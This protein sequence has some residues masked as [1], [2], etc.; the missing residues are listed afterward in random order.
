MSKPVTTA[1][2]PQIRIKIAKLNYQYWSILA[3]KVKAMMTANIGLYP[4]PNPTLVTLTTFITALDTT[5]AQ[6][7]T[8]HNKGGK[9]QILAVRVAVTDVQNTLKQLAQYVLNTVD[10]TLPPQVQAANIND[11]GFTQKDIRS[12][13]PT[14]QFVKFAKQSNTKKF[15]A[16]LRRI[17]WKKPLGLIKGSQLKS[18][19]LY[20]N[21][22]GTYLMTT[23]RCNTEMTGGVLDAVKQIKVV[24]ISRTGSGNAFVITVI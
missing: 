15:P 10:N 8:R 23:T 19:N 17:S 16:N 1:R 13:I 20:D 4:T 5:I 3:K 6:L 21:A 2:Q 18:Y 22:T 9:A 11:S 24:P 7:G 12:L 14:V